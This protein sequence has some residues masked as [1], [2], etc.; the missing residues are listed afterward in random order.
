MKTVT[1]TVAGEITVEGLAPRSVERLRLAL[2]YPHPE[3]DR[4][5]RF[6]KAA[7]DVP[8]RFECM[9]E[10][11]DGSVAIP[12]GAVD[13]LKRTLAKDEV[14]VEF[15]D[16][17]SNGSPIDLPRK[18]T[19][20]HYQATGVLRL[21]R[22]TQGMIVLPCGGGKSR[23]GAGAIAA[24]GRTT[25]VLMHTDDLIDQWVEEVQE[26]LGV[27][28]GR[29]NADRKEIDAPVVV[30]SVF[31]LAPMLEA[32]PEM[33]ARFGL[34]I[35]D[36]NHHCPATTM[37]RC[38]RRLPARYRLGLTAT[39][40]RE[41]GHGKMVDWSVGPRLLV[42]TVQEL[43]AEGHL[44]MPRLV[45]VPTTF[46]FACAPDD[47]HLLTKLHRSIVAN[48]ERNA[49]IVDLVAWQAEAGE[50]VLVLS[51]RKP[52]CKKL[53][54]M[55]AAWGLEVRVVDGETKRVDRKASIQALRDGRVSVV[56]ATSLADEG[57]NV[58]RLSK[59]VL[60]FPDRA[61]GRTVQRAGRLT[62]KWEGKDPVLYDVVDGRVGVLASRAADRRRAYASIGMEESGQATLPGV[63][64]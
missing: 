25:V 5:R 60:A 55:L 17:R 14:A 62:R 40:D 26:S 30:A 1:A 36:E 54:K 53:G 43:V 22:K 13:V 2:S 48:A 50:T 20:R 56:V 6:N 27:E 46:E 3:H 15:V 11:P 7:P 24:V 35:H 52:H 41:D 59:I 61:F 9:T 19:L 4:A 31:T 33:G 16:Q 12:R 45:T 23:C 64:P 57:L 10:R 51:N 42:K 28:P 38:L 21:E 63:T 32:N 58:P 34:V 39:P 8:L 18:P 47:P 44:M 49:A 29:V 37:Q